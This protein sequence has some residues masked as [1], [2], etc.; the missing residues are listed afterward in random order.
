MADEL[1]RLFGRLVEA[2]V[3]AGPGRLAVP[4]AAAELYER[5]VPFRSNRARLKVT[6]HKD[7]AMT[8]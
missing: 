5:L 1:D 2:L 6:T 8:V 7:Y 3:E 4:F